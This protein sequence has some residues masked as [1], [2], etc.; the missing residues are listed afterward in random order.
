MKVFTK[1]VFFVLIGIL[2]IVIIDTMLSALRDPCYCKNDS[3]AEGQCVDICWDTYGEDCLVVYPVD[4]GCEYG[5]CVTS[6]K[7]YCQNNARG[8]FSTTFHYCWD[9]DWAWGKEI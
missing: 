2:G 5:D 4:E 9:C 7:F 8:Y 3:E 1:I 6:W